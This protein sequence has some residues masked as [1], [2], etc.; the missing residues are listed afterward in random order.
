LIGSALARVEWELDINPRWKRDPNFYI[1]QTLTPVVEA[2]TVPALY[3]EA[4]S[5]EILTRI[6]NIPAILEQ[7]E[8]NLAKPPAPFAT[9]AIQA[10]E[11]VH[12]RL[13]TMAVSL[14]P[15]T[16]LHENELNDAAN[17]AADV[18]EHFRARL[19]E[20]LPSLPN[21]TALVIPMCSFSNMSLWLRTSRR[22]F[23]P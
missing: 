10:L 17:R 19:Q 5:R 22:N 12:Q 11:G 1:E 21:E 14:R 20:R 18:L 9:V 16:T 15:A 8:A 2:L 7:G 3:D 6:E 23:S 4:R 13:R